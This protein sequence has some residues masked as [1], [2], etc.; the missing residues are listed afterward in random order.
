MWG[1]VAVAAP[2]R[3]RRLEARPAC[4]ASPPLCSVGSR[5]A[6]TLRVGPLAPLPMSKRVLLAAAGCLAL[7]CRR[8]RDRLGR[9]RALAA[10]LGRDRDR[11][12]GRD[13]GPTDRVR[14]SRSRRTGRRKPTAA[15]GSEFG[16][17]PQRSLSRLASHLGT[18]TKPLWARGDGQLH[19][20]PAEL[21]R[22]AAVREHVRRPHLR[23]RRADREDPLVARRQRGQGVD[24][25]DRGAAADRHVARRH[26][27]R[28]STA[29]NGHRLWQLRTNAKVESSPVAI[30]NTVYFGA[31]DGR[32]FAVNVATGSGPVG[33]QHGRPDQLE[34][35]GVGQPHLHLDVRG[36]DPLPQ[37]D[38]RDEALEQVLQARLLPLRELLREPLDRRQAHLLRRALGKG[39]R[40]LRR[41]TATR[42]GPAASARSATRRRRSRPAACSSAASTALSAP[43]A[44]RRAR[45][46]GGAPSPA[47]S[48]ARRSSSATSSS[49]RRSSSGRTPQTRRRGRSPGRSAWASTRPGSR[50]TATTTSR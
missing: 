36:L 30:G 43:T 23:A 3:R 31:T 42:C 48:S 32:L 16:G 20:V 50:P 11:P 39:L 28:A 12:L 9:A 49:S 44:R 15:A 25:G 19:G 35:V 38:E 46:S 1:A 18:P 21:L 14:T 5:A 24:A 22:R 26:G 45:S 6:G 2:R 4:R 7:D 33:L 17:D 8:A 29:T 13:H 34:P 10:A 37:Q 27:H 40:A 41:R 47:G